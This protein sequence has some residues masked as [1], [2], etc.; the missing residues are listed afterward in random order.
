MRNTAINQPIYTAFALLTLA[1]PIERRDESGYQNE[2]ETG[3][4][5]YHR[6]TP[7]V[8]VPVNVAMR[9]FDL[10]Y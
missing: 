4:I 6:D 8:N 9:Q 7:P 1:L 10:R 2:A 3:E 5:L